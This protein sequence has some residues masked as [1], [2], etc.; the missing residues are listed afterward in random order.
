VFG[1][2]GAGLLA[3][4]AN[5]AVLGDAS[6]VGQYLSGGI[7]SALVAAAFAWS[8]LSALLGRRSPEA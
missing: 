7:V 5:L 6:S 2:A 8:L 1:L 4:S 3:F